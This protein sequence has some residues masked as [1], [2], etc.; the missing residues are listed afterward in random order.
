[1]VI[2]SRC[3]RQT[4]PKLLESG[5][6]HHGQNRFLSK[7]TKNKWDIFMGSKMISVISYSWIYK[8]EIIEIHCSGIFMGPILHQYD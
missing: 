8:G 5:G 1:M 6:F 7:F 3:K 2:N 4:W